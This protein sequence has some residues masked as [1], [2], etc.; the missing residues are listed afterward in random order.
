ML[1]RISLVGCLIVVGLVLA[2]GCQSVHWSKADTPFKSSSTK[3]KNNDPVTPARMSVIWAPTM[4]QHAHQRTKSGFGGQVYFFDA[5]N[6]PVRVDGEF[7]VYGFD[8]SN[9][10]SS[11]TADHKYVFKKER[12]PDHLNESP[13]GP[14]YSFWVPWQDSD[15][16]R[17]QI[18]LLPVFKAADGTVI[19][20][21][22]SINILPGIAPELAQQRRDARGETAQLSGANRVA[23]AHALGQGPTDI[24]QAQAIATRVPETTEHRGRTMRTT[25]IDVPRDIGSASNSSDETINGQP[26]GVITTQSFVR[27]PGQ[28]V[29]K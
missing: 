29:E 21:D 24:P 14:C 2:S 6:R 27:Q 23:P 26:F 16:P 25:T 17:R 10:R 18:A 19:K 8:D 15:G 1:S 13:V 4:M 7:L 20:G 5:E 12:L 28:P 3:K 11:Q 9:D 22:Q